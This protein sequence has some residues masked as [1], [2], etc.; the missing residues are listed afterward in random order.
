MDLSLMGLS[1]IVTLSSIVAILVPGAFRSTNVLATVQG[2]SSDTRHHPTPELTVRKK[3][4][5]A[6]ALF[7]LWQ[8][9]V[10]LS[11]GWWRCACAHQP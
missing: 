11:C 9:R 3:Q 7:I 2:S 10:A 4:V 8:E 1:S 6:Y 5:L